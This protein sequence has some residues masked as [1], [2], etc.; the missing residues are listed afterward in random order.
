MPIVYSIRNWFGYFHGE[1]SLALDHHRANNSVKT[2][3]LFDINLL[4]FN[5]F[6]YSL[7]GSVPNTACSCSH[8]FRMRQW[9]SSIDDGMPLPRTL[10]PWAH[11][12]EMS[13][14]TALLKA[15]CAA[16]IIKYG[17]NFFVHFFLS[18]TCVCVRCSLCAM[19]PSL[20]SDLWNA[21]KR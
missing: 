1:H 15:A 16:C 18:H 7:L 14:A 8:I 9:I 11:I 3:K 21:Y 12:F 6:F 4:L 10:H 17:R 20:S 5:P 13:L 19:L 2:S